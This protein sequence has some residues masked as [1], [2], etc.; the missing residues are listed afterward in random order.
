MTICT[1][2]SGNTYE[3]SF[4]RQLDGSIRAYITSQPDYGSQSD[5][6]AETHRMQ[7]EDGRWY[8]AWDEALYTKEEAKEVAAEWSRRTDV[9]IN[10]GDWVPYK[11]SAQGRSAAQEEVPDDA[12]Y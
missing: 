10:T 1:T 9:Y 2:S 12:I 4:E 11:K 5:T 6:A 7:D 8:V 3:F